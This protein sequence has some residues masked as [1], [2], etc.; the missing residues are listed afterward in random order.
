MTEPEA[1][2]LIDLE[3]SITSK[4]TTYW[5]GNRH[6]YTTEI[7][8]AGLFSEGIS[9]HEVGRDFDKRTIRVAKSTVDNMYR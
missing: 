1:Y 2:Y 6:G 8:E 9:Q 5:K 3:R 7:S 4:V